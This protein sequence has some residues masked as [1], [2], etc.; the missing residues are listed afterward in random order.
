MEK[1]A[2]YGDKTCAMSLQGS[3]DTL[4]RW[5]GQLSRH[6]MSNYVRNIGVK[7]Y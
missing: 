4:V 6:V 3:V 5:G 1:Y 7:K 2:M